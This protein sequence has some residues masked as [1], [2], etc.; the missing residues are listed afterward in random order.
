MTLLGVH[1]ANVTNPFDVRLG[2]NRGFG[3]CRSLWRAFQFGWL[4]LIKPLL[5]ILIVSLGFSIFIIITIGI[6]PSS[7]AHH[8][9]VDV[10]LSW[11]GTST[12]YHYNFNR[13]QPPKRPRLTN[14]Y[15]KL[16]AHNPSELGPGEE[17]GHGTSGPPGACCWRVP[18]VGNGKDPRNILCKPGFYSEY[19]FFRCINWVM[20]L[21][22][23]LRTNLE[24]VALRTNIYLYLQ[25]RPRSLHKN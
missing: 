11:V 8:V 21:V 20:C 15:S 24:I 7:I 2:I 9:L 1:L 16:K 3:N 10:F 18:K 4:L 13:F 14:P 22:E 23:Y 6:T 5:K 19:I 17:E 25:N 12:Q